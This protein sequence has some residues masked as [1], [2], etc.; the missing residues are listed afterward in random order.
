MATIKTQGGKVLLEEGKPSCSC[1]KGACCGD[2]GLCSYI[3]KK[4]CDEL[5]S[6]WQGAGTKCDPNP[7]GSESSGDGIGLS[8]L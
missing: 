7:C 8:L 5:G 4:E 6:T 3:T 1:C 2:D